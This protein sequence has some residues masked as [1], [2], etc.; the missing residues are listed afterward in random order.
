MLGKE[1]GI[2]R[3]ESNR[4]GRESNRMLTIRKRARLRR[5]G[6]GLKLLEK[7]EGGR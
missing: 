7:L 3:W 4:K 6:E 1:L 2:S 5:M